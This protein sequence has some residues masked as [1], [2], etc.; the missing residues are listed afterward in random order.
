MRD[1][2]TVLYERTS[3]IHV[4]TNFTYNKIEIILQI[5]SFGTPT[6]TEILKKWNGMHIRQQNV[7][8]KIDSAVFKRKPKTFFRFSHSQSA[9]VEDLV[10]T[11]FLT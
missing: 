9:L 1:T 4:R 5:F 3:N 6:Q 11:E 7:F 2:H 10:Y 8:D